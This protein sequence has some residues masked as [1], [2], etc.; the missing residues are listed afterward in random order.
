[1]IGKK[2]FFFILVL[3]LLTVL[4]FKKEEFED[5]K[6]EMKVIFLMRSYNRPEY[7][8]QTLNFLDNSDVNYC[9]KKIIYDD[10]SNKDTLKIL[11]K[12][13]NKYD[14]IY[15]DNNL[16]QKSM[17]KFLDIVEK[18]YS[19]YDFICYLD[20]DA[21][22]KPYFIKSCIGTFNLIMKKENLKNDKIILTGFNCPNHKVL[23]EFEK[24]VSK[25]SIGGIHMFF[26]KS[27][28]HKIKDWWNL[29]EDWG[30]VKEFK[31]EDGNFFA[32]KPSI[33]QHIGKFGYNSNGKKYD[34]SLDF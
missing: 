5:N 4:Y 27:V 34:K 21:Q 22:V 13:Q 19:D 18:K 6:N 12:Y 14:I 7:L 15:N 11:K 1:M 23:N 20:N 25:N 8:A 3:I 16:K 17:V 2:I 28:I 26:H 31:K 30:I 24:Y 33:I 10:N 9:L 29:N 32:T